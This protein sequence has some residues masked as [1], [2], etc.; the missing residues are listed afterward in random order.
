VDSRLKGGVL[1]VVGGME[2]EP[3]IRDARALG[4]PFTWSAVGGNKTKGR[5]GW[6]C[7]RMRA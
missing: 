6:W 3:T 2:L 4:Y 1:W 5:A 7:K